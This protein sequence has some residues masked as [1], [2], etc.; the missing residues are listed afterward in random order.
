M[1]V[2]NES[3]VNVFFDN[4]QLVH[5]RGPLVEETHYYPFGLTMAGISSSALGKLGNKIKFQGQELQNKEFSDGSGLEMYEFKWR[6]HDPQIGRFGSIDPLAD[7]YV[8][9]SPYAFSENKVTGHVEL[10]GL[11]SIPFSM[12]DLWRSLGISQSS[13]PIQFVKNVGKETL[14]PK[15]WVE[16]TVAAGQ[17]A[18]PVT[19]T[20]I[21]TGGV[22]DGAILTAETNAL[23]KTLPEASPAINLSERAK[24]IHSVLDP[25]T[26]RMNT[27][28]VASATTQEGDNVI[29]VGSN[30]RRLRTAQRQI[31]K[32]SETAVEGE[33]HAE[34]TILNHASANNMQVTAVAASR[35]ICSNCATAIQNAGATAASPLKVS[36]I[37]IVSD[38]TFV[39]PPII[40]TP[41]TQ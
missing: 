18:V 28:A 39:K 33:G 4:L 21:M 2:S 13:D 40:I 27:T 11:E 22:G 10:E 9:N 16:A 6:M 34:A 24:E 35:P 1:Y 31:L 26:Q 36:P 14:K 8:Y 32:Q 3:P 19:L 15:T 17:I 41:R 29:L 7:K 37:K 5:T 30:E 25:R 23:Q 38:A 20:T 12:A